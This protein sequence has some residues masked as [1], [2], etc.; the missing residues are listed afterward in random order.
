MYNGDRWT[1][2]TAIH[3]RTRPLGLCSTRSLT[4]VTSNW[5]TCVLIL[6]FEGYKYYVKI[7]SFCFEIYNN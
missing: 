7:P 1:T 4:A 3:V 2:T 5:Q 6:Y